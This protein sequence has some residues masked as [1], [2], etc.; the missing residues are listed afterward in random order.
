MVSRPMLLCFITRV[1]KLQSAALSTQRPCSWSRI[2]SKSPHYLAMD[3]SRGLLAVT[4]YQKFLSIHDL[5][6]CEESWSDLRRF[7]RFADTEVTSYTTD[8]F[9]L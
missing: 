6:S 7:I 8:P 9:G 2:P 4:L 3:L 5:D 1:H